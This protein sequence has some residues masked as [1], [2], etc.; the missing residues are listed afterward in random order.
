MTKRVDID[1]AMLESL[2]TWFSARSM[3]YRGPHSFNDRD[4]SEL[5]NRQIELLR[6]EKS[7]HA[8]ETREAEGGKKF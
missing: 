4:V 2:S 8:Y 1:I 7:V 3:G 6:V 5:L